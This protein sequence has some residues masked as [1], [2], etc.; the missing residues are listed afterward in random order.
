MSP[1]QRGEGPCQTHAC[2]RSHTHVNTLNGRSLWSP[3][4]SRTGRAPAAF[5]V[6]FVALCPGRGSQCQPTACQGFPA[7]LIYMCTHP[8]VTTHTLACSLTKHAHTRMHARARTRTHA[9]IR[10]NTHTLLH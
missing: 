6:L 7:R 1:R 5:T 9:D 10:I 2:T 4:W 8:C 3:Q